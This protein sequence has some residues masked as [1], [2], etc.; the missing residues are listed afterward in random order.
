MKTNNNEIKTV[1]FGGGCFWC[2]EAVFKDVK[3]VISV[4]P[5]YG[6]GVT[7]YPSYDDVSEDTT[8]H[9]EVI[10]IRYDPELISFRT[11]L[12][13]FFATHNPTTLNRQGS[14]IGTRYRSII[15]YTNIHQKEEAYK[16][17]DEI[18]DSEEFEGPVVTEVVP[19][20]NFYEAEGYHKNYF[21]KN[22]RSMYCQVII[23][24]KLDKVHKEFSS[25]FITN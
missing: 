10:R 4:T 11:L 17:I 3:G 7:E 13:L 2:T 5:G 24:P 23:N 15:F 8:G 6:G 22:Q 21:A 9:A 1:Y 20:V 19:F 12:I 14:D 25:L 18:N 16:L